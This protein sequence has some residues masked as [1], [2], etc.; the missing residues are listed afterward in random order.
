[1]KWN[2]DSSSMPSYLHVET[3]GEPTSESFAAMWDE[4]LQSDFWHPGFTVLI[5][6]R[7]LKPFKDADAVTTSSIDY[8][9]KNNARIGKAC[10]SVVS[11]R[12]ENFKY[13]R[14]FQYGTRLHGC[15]AV[16][17]VFGTETQAVEWL[18]HFSLIRSK[19]DDR[20]AA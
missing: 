4:I 10:I 12:P 7:K 1:M 3:D 20:V 18:N 8:F 15:D 2:I 11:S 9:A 17:Q 5:D 16:L 13:A 6:N 19:Q 14:Q